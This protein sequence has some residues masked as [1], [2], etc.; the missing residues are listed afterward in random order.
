MY[1][2]KVTEPLDKLCCVVLVEFDV[3]EV[4]LQNGGAWVPDKEKHQLGLA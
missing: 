4:H 3:R 2:P 1:L